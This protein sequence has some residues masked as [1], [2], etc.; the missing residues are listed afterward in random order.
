MLFCDRCCREYDPET[1]QQRENAHWMRNGDRWAFT[2]REA[3]AEAN[4]APVWGQ[5]A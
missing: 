1:Y 3:L 4:S 5:R 2:F